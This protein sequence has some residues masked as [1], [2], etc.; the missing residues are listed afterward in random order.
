MAPQPDGRIALDTFERIENEIE[1]LAL[2][3]FTVTKRLD[4]TAVAA[5]SADQGRALVAE[6]VRVMGEFD[7]LALFISA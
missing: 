4:R 6:V 2:P 7:R 5:L 1:Q 3:Y